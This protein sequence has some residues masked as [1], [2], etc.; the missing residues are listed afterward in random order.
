[1]DAKE[2]WLDVVGYEGLYQVSNF[3]S[4]KSLPKYNSKTEKILRQTINPRD[5]RVSV[6]LSKS[7]TDHKRV[8]VHRLVALAFLEN[9]NNYPEINHKDENPQNNRVENLEWCTRKYNMN[10]GT[11][12]KRLNLKNM[13]PVEYCEKDHV[14]RFASIRSAKKY[15]FDGSGILRSIKQGKEYKGKRWRYAD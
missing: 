7:P 10:Y 14:V 5:G 8:S 11:T 1:M 6:M 3:G 2:N 13:K 15:G 12:P 4:V 9:P